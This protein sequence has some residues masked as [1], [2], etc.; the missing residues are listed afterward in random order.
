MHMDT[1]CDEKCEKLTKY[2]AS[3][4]PK[5]NRTVI[6]PPNVLTLAVAME[7]MPHIAIAVG[8]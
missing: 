1:A 3:T 8:R 2:A 4:N 7:I 6:N 5:K